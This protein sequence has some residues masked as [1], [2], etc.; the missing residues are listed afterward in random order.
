MPGVLKPSKTK[1]KIRTHRKR[2]HMESQSHSVCLG[3]EKPHVSPHI[4]RTREIFR[5]TA[6]RRRDAGGG[7]RDTRLRACRVG[8]S[9]SEQPP[10]RFEALLHGGEQK[11]EPEGRYGHRR[12]QSGVVSLEVFNLEAG[13]CRMTLSDRGSNNLSPLTRNNTPI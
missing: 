3:T 4:S 2:R 6:T 11:E 13:E 10:V 9:R 7:I 1:S 12:G 8:M 5:H